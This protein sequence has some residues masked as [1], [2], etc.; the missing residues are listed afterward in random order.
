MSSRAVQDKMGVIYT[1]WGPCIVTAERGDDW[2][3]ENR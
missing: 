2:Q 3:Y 1:V